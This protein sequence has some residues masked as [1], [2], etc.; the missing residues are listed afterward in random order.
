[1]LKCSRCNIVKN[2]KNNFYKNAN[3]NHYSP[4]KKC[5]PKV[6]NDPKV[7]QRKYAQRKA[8]INSDPSF[9]LRVRASS[10]IAN[11]LKASGGSKLGKS[12]LDKL[13]YTIDDL[14]QHLELQFEL[15]M[16]WHNWGVY[17][18]YRSDDNEP[19]T[20]KWQIDHIIPYHEL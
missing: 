7:R 8:R 1:M 6:D 4:C 10:A 14:K 3:N 15:W 16:N 20:W 12:I 17:N 11:A 19:S 13:P 9:K 18:P 5:K 2:K